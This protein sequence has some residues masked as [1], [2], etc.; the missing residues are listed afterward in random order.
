MKKLLSLSLALLLL[1]FAFAG[2]N[3]SDGG[4]DTDTAGGTTAD[5]AA[6]TP[7]T[8]ADTSGGAPTDE[9][10]PL[11]PKY[12]DAIT[13]SDYSKAE[14]WLALPETAE[15]E[16]DVFFLYP[17]VWTRQTGQPYY[18]EL[19]NPGMLAGAEFVMQA[20][21]SAFEGVGNIYAP[22]Y[23]QLDAAW[24]LSSPLDTQE[25]YFNGVPYTDVI[26]AFE[27]YL[28]HYNNGRPFI[29]AGH[30]QGS[31][32]VKSMVKLYMKEHPDVYERM[33]AAY[34]I[35]Y[36]VSESELAANPHMKFAESADDTGVI[37]SWNVEAPD[38]TIENPLAPAGSISIN[39]ITWTRG[40]E[41]ATKEQNLG[42]LICNRL[43]GT[44]TEKQH[45][46]DATVNLERGTV[47]CSSVDIDEYTVAGGLFPR[48]VYHLQ[49]YGFYYYNIRANAKNR[50]NKYL[51]SKGIPPVFSEVIEATDYADPT[52]WLS[53]PD[54]AHA[55]DVFYL[56]PTSWNKTD[57]D[58]HYC[59]IDNPT[60][61][62][63][64]QFQV[65][66][67]ASVF[68]GVANIYAPLYRQVD[69]LWL[70]N[71]GNLESGQAYFDGIPYA[72]ALAAFEYYLEH[73]NNGK[74][75][76]LAGH[77]QGANVTYSILKYY[78]AE[79]PDVY[80]RMVCAYIVGYS[81]TEK[82]LAAYPHLKFAEGATDT[83]V[84]VSWNTEAP[85]T[86]DNALLFDGA[87][88]INPI[89]WTRTDAPAAKE[90]NLGSV[91]ANRLTG[92]TEEKAQFADATVDPARGSVIC[93]SV[94]A[95]VY[96][97]GGMFP[98]GS[99]HMYEYGFYYHNIRAN[100]AARVA[101][102]L[103]ATE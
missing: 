24:L 85:G 72:D 62:A 42:S 60:L 84:I 77:S 76:I 21:A 102:F 69:A 9:G 36:Y 18:C 91:L 19:D 80:E 16:V 28:E 73:Y 39:P 29:L 101:A 5:T 3:P 35:G 89:T 20:Q 56:Y 33:V 55:V 88:S 64:G 74:P 7:S 10:L 66:A 82:E 49:D 93:A 37:I 48:G 100:A 65:G 26:A 41:T 30:S 95:S 81:V 11:P 12:G 17:T 90:Q 58:P 52:H 50:V 47:I 53:I 13:P 34:A 98:V 32:M 46:A 86:V 54:T 63:G 6:T 92:T 67:Q 79:H 78:M 75:F 94:D 61:R 15:H 83:G 57:A 96:A 99:Y 38:L 68:E 70:L 59:S 45:E 87:I 44:V 1:C 2:C 43:A 22:Y 14:H 25:D 71:S 40:T 97:A 31:S 27:Y 103:D 8:E 51:E 23:R 4:K